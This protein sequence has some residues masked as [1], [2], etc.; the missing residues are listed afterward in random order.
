MVKTSKIT[1]TLPDPIVEWLQECAELHFVTT[2]EY[3]R[4][5]VTDFFLRANP[6]GSTVRETAHD[7]K[8][9]KPRS[10]T[11]G[12]KGVYPYGK[13]WKA[14]I[15]TNGRQDRIG[16][17]DTPEEA[18]Q[19]YDEVLVQRV[20][21]PG[22]AVNAV[23]LRDQAAR[24]ADAPFMAKL[25]HGDSLTPAEMAAW[26]RASPGSP[27][28]SP[29]AVQTPS[30]PAT[31]KIVPRPLRREPGPSIERPM[32]NEG[33]TTDDSKDRTWNSADRTK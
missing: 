21:V 24:E 31:I 26:K 20:G 11:S 22:A 25:L 18:A 12:Y 6:V 5:L 7:A 27:M 2:A 4:T 29:M 28:S 16:V 9:A 13:R 19:A 10:T 3:I 14:V 8:Y 32:A 30:A 1:V 17:F 33:S 15:T 23:T